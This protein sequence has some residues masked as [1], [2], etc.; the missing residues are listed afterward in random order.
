MNEYRQRKIQEEK[1]KKKKCM[2]RVLIQTKPFRSVSPMF[3]L[4]FIRPIKCYDFGISPN[5]SM[6]WI[7]QRS[8]YKFFLCFVS[9]SKQFFLQFCVHIQGNNSRC[10]EIESSAGDKLENYMNKNDMTRDYY[11]IRVNNEHDSE[12]T[13]IAFN[14]IQNFLFC[15]A[16]RLLCH[17]KLYKS[18]IRVQCV[19][20]WWM[21][22]T[23][24]A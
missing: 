13:R 3:F 14:S 11:C 8:Q 18:F 15:W 23:G 24:L 16:F 5:V 9:N 22:C 6:L 20:I 2:V 4:S 7:V 12:W 19:Y 10:V 1:P 17:M 21:C